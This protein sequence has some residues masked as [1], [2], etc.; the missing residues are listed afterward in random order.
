MLV[1]QLIKFG[2]SFHAEEELT[3][4]EMDRPYIIYNLKIRFQGV[5]QNRVRG[6]CVCIPSKP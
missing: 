1:E 4:R 3:H 6:V 5:C 2:K